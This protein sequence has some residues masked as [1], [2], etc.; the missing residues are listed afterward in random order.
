MEPIVI[1]KAL[2][3]ILLSCAIASAYAIPAK[4]GL[5][6]MRQ[7][8]GTEVSVRLVGDEHAH[9]YTTPDGYPL[10]YASGTFYYASFDGKEL[11]S[12]G[13]KYNGDS[14]TELSL[15]SIDRRQAF[16]SVRKHRASRSNSYPGL[17]NEGTFP[18]TGS[19]KALVILVEYS[20]VKMTLS[21]AHDYFDRML[22]QTGF[23]DYDA[24]GSAIDFFSENSD[25]RF[26]PEFDVVGPVTLSRPREYYG[27]N[28]IY[29]D[30][31]PE[32][33][34]I[35]ACQLLD[36]EIDFTKYD[37]DGDGVIDNVF[38]FY[39]GQS[40][41]AGGGDD[42]VWPHSS[43]IALLGDYTFDGKK[44]D[45]YACSNEWQE[46][47]PDGVGTFIHEF[48]HVLGLPDLYA[49]EESDAF[50]PGPW[51]TLD[52]GPYNN[53]GCTPPL[54]SSFERTALGWHKAAEITEACD[55][56][57]LPLSYGIAA[58]VKTT[59]T[60]EYFL[61][62]N[63]RREGWDTYLPGEGMLIW[64]IHYDKGMWSTNTV[65]NDAYHQHVDLVEADGRAT[66]DSRTGDSFPGAAGVSSHILK[67]WNGNLDKLPMTEIAENGEMVTFKVAGGK[68]NTQQERSFAAQE[69]GAHGFTAIWEARPDVSYL[70]TVSDEDG[71]VD[72][73]DNLFVGKRSSYAVTGLE[74]DTKYM[75]SVQGLD[76][77]SLTLASKPIT[78]E[79]TGQPLP[80]LYAEA[81]AAEDVS[82][83]GFTAR[84]VALPG[85]E[86]YDL[87]V[88]TK[89]AS[90]PK[91]D[92]MAFDEG[93]A[94]LGGWDCSSNMIYNMAGMAGSSA[95][96]LR[97]G[98]GQGLTSPVY[99]EGVTGLS[100]WSRGS[101]TS[102][103]DKLRFEAWDGNRWNIVTDEAI[104]TTKGGATI[105]VDEMP[106]GTTAIRITAMCQKGNVA[107]DDVTVCYGTTYVAAAVEGYNPLNVAGATECAV[108][109][110][111]AGK[112]YYYTVVGRG[113]TGLSQVS[114][115]MAVDTATSGIVEIGN[116]TSINIDGLTVNVDG[117]SAS[118]Q[119]RLY[120]LTGR[121]AASA[122][123]PCR[124]SANA[125]GIYILTVGND[126]MKVILR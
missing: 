3:P 55:A 17:Y 52:A 80:E 71:A 93:L 45:Y 57:L 24:T 46:G 39:A 21:N 77:V 30:R 111:E 69:V 73:Y 83:E 96:S 105:R 60:N 23:S 4:P 65:N 20:D 72:G 113:A 6:S 99:A 114:Q 85:A 119:T 91:K 41:A 90:G 106:A 26:T 79:T 5:I 31:H 18:R 82:A 27:G 38:V 44:L 70:L 66:A 63:R 92:V 102:E 68:A 125:P 59:D 104:T 43:N 81:L 100:L 8:D 58:V 87:T 16:R 7:P 74:A 88:Y 53:N 109:G 1:K 11:R 101:N 19:P 117:V 122:I 115:E 28:T 35:E 47:R 97:L 32:E 29:G 33:M 121:I 34:V 15:P 76:G 10:V 103:G 116:S 84:W 94:N 42:T 2:A 67:T 22:N 78:T 95:P 112:T 51:S 124:V 62:E 9:L 110:L 48:S 126:T 120:D 107:I 37:T 108:S 118:T 49:T 13:L 54:Y 86:S 98:T 25:G 14:K 123:G 56:T 64:H 75:Y 40:E 89:T 50:T 12:S 36:D 61:L